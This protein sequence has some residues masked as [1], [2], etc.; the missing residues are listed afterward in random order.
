MILS[1]DREARQTPTS[2][3]AATTPFSLSVLTATRGK[4]T[5]TI[6]ASV[7]G[8]PITNAES[9]AI[10]AGRLE[11]VQV[12]GLTG[13]QGLLRTIR[14]NQALVHG[15]VTGSLPGCAFPLVT[16]EKLAQAK[17]GTLAEGTIARSKEFLTYPPEVYLL[18]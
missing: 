4:A 9:L 10:M 17:P 3:D 13:L 6:S 1:D 7:S 11:H 5:K 14:P 15:I 16:K 2:G 18:Y 12:A 8:Q